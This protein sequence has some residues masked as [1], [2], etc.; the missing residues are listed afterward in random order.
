[1]NKG[2]LH[3]IEIGPHAALRGPLEQIRKGLNNPEHDFISSST[4]DRKKDSD[5][6]MLELARTLFQHGY[7]LQWSAVNSMGHK[8]LEPIP[9]LPSYPWDYSGGILFTEPRASH[10]IKNRKY[11]RHVLLGSL[12]VTG[13]GIEHRWRN[14]L[15]VNEVPWLQDHK[16]ESEVL[17]PGAGYLCMAMEGLKQIRGL[18]DVSDD[19]ER[20][21]LFRDVKSNSS[22]SC[23]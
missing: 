13:D 7:E 22:I 3:I 8:Q 12:Q 23:S 9:D 11:P 6:C 17:F 15:Q 19:R 16:L 14:V 18:S 2:K 4:L 10:E 20:R 21:F 1:M 5:K